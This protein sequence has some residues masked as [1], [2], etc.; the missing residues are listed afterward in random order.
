MKGQGYMTFEEFVK[1]NRPESSN[2]ELP[3]TFGNRV[4]A[5]L[6]WHLHYVYEGEFVLSNELPWKEGG[7]IYQ[8]AFVPSAGLRGTFLDEE[9][10]AVLLTIAGNP[11]PLV[12]SLPE[13]VLVLPISEWS[14]KR[15]D[16]DIVT[17]SWCQFERH[18]K[19]HAIPYL[20]ALTKVLF[21]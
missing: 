5:T 20:E 11:Q 16:G 21:G 1:A 17:V 9:R 6:Y 15:P 12:I 3:G 2:I 19:A 10:E 8:I 13:P 14:M 18:A 4:T 7:R